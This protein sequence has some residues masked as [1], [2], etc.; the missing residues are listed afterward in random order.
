MNEI[1][2]NSSGTKVT[3]AEMAYLL[4]FAFLSIGK[5]SDLTAGNR[6]LQILGVL[7]FVFIVVKILITK[8]TKD[9]LLLILSIG[10]LG[11][12]TYYT[13]SKEGLLFSILAVVGLKNVSLYRVFTLSFWLGITIFLFKIFSSLVGIGSINNVMVRFNGQG[14]E[15]IS[16][17]S[18]GYGHPNTA[19]IVLFNLVCLYVFLNYRK[20]NLARIISIALIF[21]GFYYLTLSRTG[22]FCSMFLVMLMF[23][24]KFKLIERIKWM[25]QFTPIICFVFSFI[26]GYF[27]NSHNSILVKLDQ[28][29]SGRLS[30]E[31]FFLNNYNINLFGQKIVYQTG[32]SYLVLDNFYLNM[33]L[34]Y[35]A[36]ITMIYLI[37]NWLLLRKL[38]KNKNN[39]VMCLILVCYSIYGLTETFLTNVFLNT[40]FLFLAYLLYKPKDE[41]KL[42]SGELC[43]I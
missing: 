11:V 38:L 10:L 8:Y 1:G 13:S 9:E 41:E 19:F 30:L 2:L 17:N 7:G 27:F 34:S 23:L 3:L 16:R 35:G 15:Q 36:I 42:K 22:F 25:L 33:L 31:K 32:Q 26:T 18:L 24:L 43:K 6:I 5:Y 40:S 39:E 12:I 20:I 28:L 21:L 29:L 14:W 4:F 37:S